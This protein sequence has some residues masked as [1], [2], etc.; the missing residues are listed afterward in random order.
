MKYCTES[1][2]FKWRLVNRQWN[3]ACS[4]WLRS[5]KISKVFIMGNEQVESF[6]RTI[7]FP[8]ITLFNS[9]ALEELTVCTEDGSSV[10]YKFLS[11]FGSHMESLELHH[12]IFPDVET[13]LRVLG[14]LTYLKSLALDVSSFKSARLEGLPGLGTAA[15]L[16]KLEVL[17][18]YFTGSTAGLFENFVADFVAYIAP[19]IKVLKMEPPDCYTKISAETYE[20]F[21]RC[22]LGCRRL[23]KFG[24]QLCL[25]EKLMKSVTSAR[26]PLTDVD[27]VVKEDLVRSSVL[28]NMLKALAGTLKCLKLTF[29]LN[30][31]KLR[32]ASFELPPFTALEELTLKNFYGGAEALSFLQKCQTLKFLDL[33]GVPH[34]E[35]MLPQ[36]MKALERA[37]RLR[38]VPCTYPSSIAF[39]RIMALFPNLNSLYIEDVQDYALRGIFMELPK[40]EVLTLKGHF[41]DEGIAGIPAEKCTEISNFEL[42]EE[43]D[44]EYL[45]VSPFIGDLKSEYSASALALS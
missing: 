4:A 41:T 22:A 1:D 12:V 23:Q 28:F 15:A 26:L 8:N 11:R 7:P 33:L 16:E 44:P 10:A 17:N 3:F 30:S 20:T 21:V 40:L 31:M 38:I 19:N 37:Q 39:Q 6:L 18:L 5:V 24:F 27:L 13:L 9:F 35:H 29:R 14:R 2:V 45:R 34:Y 42:I 25:S 43:I 36:R 32:N